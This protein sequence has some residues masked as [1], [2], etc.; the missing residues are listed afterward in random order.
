MASLELAGGEQVGAPSRSR[1][2][3]SGNG[4]SS[5]LRLGCRP[6]RSSAATR[7]GHRGPEHHAAAGRGADR[8][9]HLLGTGALEQ[10]ARSAGPDRAEDGVVVLVHGEHHDPRPGCRP[11]MNRVASIPSSCGIWMSMTHDV[12]RVS[13][14]TCSASRPSA[15]A[16][17]TSMPECAEQ[18]D[19]AVAHDLV[20]VDDH[21]AD[22]LGR[23]W[24]SLPT[25]GRGSQALT[26]VPPPAG[27]VISARPPSSAARSRS[28]TRP[29]P[30]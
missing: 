10:V 15:A 11:T 5:G 22:G 27:H 17:T 8:G 13:P 4:S 23:S 28:D 1:S 24:G 25:S 6:R 30:A 26:M 7:C 19:Q 29:T 3:R 18:R 12:G 16:P 9:V 2:V 14:T 20:V 21:D